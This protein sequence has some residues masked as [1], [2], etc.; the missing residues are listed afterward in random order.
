MK[1][2]LRWMKSA[3]SFLKGRKQLRDWNIVVIVETSFKSICCRSGGK[4]ECCTLWEKIKMFS[5]RGRKRGGGGG[6]DVSRLFSYWTKC[7]M[8]T[9][10]CLL[11]LAKGVCSSRW[12]GQNW[13]LVFAL[14]KPAATATFSKNTNYIPL[15]KIRD[16]LI[17][18]LKISSFLQ[19]KNRRL[20]P[21]SMLVSFCTLHSLFYHFPT[22]TTPKTQLDRWSQGMQQS[23]PITSALHTPLLC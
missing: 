19:I 3:T 12:P 15:V 14:A 2:K 5:E 21:Q 18:P 11:L 22:A 6:G 23:P 7:A 9:M 20:H 1:E 4:S 13:N 17:C 10:S 16:K 8:V